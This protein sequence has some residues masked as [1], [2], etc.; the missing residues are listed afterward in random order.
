MTTE[1][2]TVA[3]ISDRTSTTELLNEMNL[4]PEAARIF[5]IVT[6]GFPP[7]EAEACVKV[8]LYSDAT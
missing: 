6:I 5:L 1:V 7:S 2:L 4:E 3:P 8:W